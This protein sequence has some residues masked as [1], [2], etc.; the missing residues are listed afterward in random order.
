MCIYTSDCLGFFNFAKM[1]GELENGSSRKVVQSANDVLNCFSAVTV[2]YAYSEYVSDFCH[3]QTTS[4]VN[5]FAYK[6]WNKFKSKSEA[7]NHQLGIDKGI[8]LWKNLSM[9]RCIN[10][11][12]SIKGRQKLYF[13]CSSL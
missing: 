9:M 8:S 13:K 6:T 10:H 5:Y 4:K 3:I 7:S 11:I 2:A 12:Y 1:V